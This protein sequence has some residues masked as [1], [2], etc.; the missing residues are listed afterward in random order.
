MKSPSTSHRFGRLIGLIAALAMPLLP[1]IQA[2]KP[3]PRVVAGVTA[4]VSATLIYD[5]A[6]AK[7]KKKT[8]KDKGSDDE[9]SAKKAKRKATSTRTG[10]IDI[11][12]KAGKSGKFVDISVDTSASCAHLGENLNEDGTS[13]GGNCT[14]DGHDGDYYGRCSTADEAVDLQVIGCSGEYLTSL[15]TAIKEKK[16]GDK[17]VE[18]PADVGLFG[19]HFDLDTATAIYNDGA[20]ITN[21]HVHEW[22]DKNDLTTIDF[23][24]IV[25]GS[26]NNVDETFSTSQLFYVTVANAALSTGGVL[27]INGV[28]YTVEDYEALV[29][30]HIAG[31][32]PL[33]KYILGNPSE[34]QL[35]AGVRKLTSLSLTFDVNSI[36]VGGL[37]PTNTGCVKDNDYGPNGE[38]RNGALLVQAVNSSTGTL[39][40]TLH[41]ATA[42][43]LWEAS[44]F[45]HWDPSECYHDA[46][47]QTQYD[48]CLT[49]GSCISP[50]KYKK[51]YTDSNY[52]IYM[53]HK[54]GNSGKYN[55]LSI[56]KNAYCAH[57]GAGDV[58]QELDADGN[59]TGA[60]CVP[61]GHSG[62]SYM[63]PVSDYAGTG[64]GKDTVPACPST[65]EDVETT[66]TTVTTE[67]MDKL[68]DCLDDEKGGGFMGYAE[69]GRIS[70][71]QIIDE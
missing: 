11:C 60:A 1:A 22:D 64:K 34:A 42:N 18:Q 46:N 17:A 70:W 9:Q 58:G 8:K 16:E 51:N 13:A 57:R 40:A 21:E 38:Y 47:W 25:G 32:D 53:C 49:D 19:G 20:G 65:T 6:Y 41:H 10:K 37:H 69:T 67:L 52:K 55:L 35:T 23:F 29:A 63:G 48:N 68:D 33:Q 26:F 12:H 56:S 61:P 7:K 5:A 3:L 71:K 2:M 54:A 15:L 14:Q 4:L 45:W 31:G 44:V 39:H 59:P 27:E 28:R 36:L 50:S 30:G 43:L 66:Y 62:D 24:N